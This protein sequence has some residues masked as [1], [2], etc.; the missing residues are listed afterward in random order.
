MS[1][2]FISDIH[3]DPS[4]P[5]VKQAFIDFLS[6]EASTAKALYLLGD[7]F[8]AWIGDDFST[9]FVDEI[10][11]ALKG[12]SDSGVELYF[13]HG[14]RDFLIG[15]QFCDEIGATLLQDPS[16]LEYD[17]KRYLLMHGDSLCLDD[18]D[19]LKFRQMARSDAWQQQVLAQPIEARLALAAKMREQSG[20][21]MSEKSADI[22]D[23]TT[24]E[25]DR[26][27]ALNNADVL[28]HGHTHR[29][30]IH[31][32]QDNKTR[33]VLSDWT[34]HCQYLRLEKDKTLQLRRLDFA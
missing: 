11:W 34:D 12:L 8:E 27:L 21:A 16:I 10:K 5:R 23:V 6:T 28:I 15:Q 19:Y 7:I 31:Q 2:V 33:V 22:M 14:N 25:V 3:L 17:N 18:V 32:H 26:Q 30:A 13:M 24:S 4:Q 29:P 9:P 20:A 1:V